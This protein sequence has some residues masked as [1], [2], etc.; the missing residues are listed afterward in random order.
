MEKYILDTHVV[1]WM[2]SD[3]SK[4][5]EKVKQ[6]IL[7]DAIKCV[8]IASAWEVAIK[9]GKNTSEKIFLDLPGGL[10]EFYRM[11]DVNEFLILPVQRPYLLYVPTLPPFHKDPFDRLIISTAIAEDLTLITSDENMQKYDVSWVW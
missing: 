6:I 9:L 7:S 8:S 2:T 4:L 5:T 11:L 1:L 10:S 3:P